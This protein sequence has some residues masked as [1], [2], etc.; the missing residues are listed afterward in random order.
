MFSHIAGVTSL[1]QLASYFWFCS[2]F[3]QRVRRRTPA[4][5]TMGL[6]TRL[7]SFGLITCALVVTSPL[8]GSSH[9]AQTSG[10]PRLVFMEQS[11]HT[12][13]RFNWRNLTCPVCKAL[14]VILDIALM[15]IFK[16]S[17]LSRKI[18]WILGSLC[19]C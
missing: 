15:V 6:Q 17:L 2:C 1:T 5:R 8:F 3:V 16:K 12:G 14:F 4:I 18:K 7:L 19:S 9:P 11:V 13:V 10:Q